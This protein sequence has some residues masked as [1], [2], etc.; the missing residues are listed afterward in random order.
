MINILSRQ[1]ALVAEIQALGPFE[2]GE[3]IRFL[4]G[5][6]PAAREDA[7]E[8]AGVLRMA[9]PVEGSWEYAG[10]TVRGKGT[11]GVEI[12]IHATAQAAPAALVQVRRILSLDVDGSGFA[13]LGETDPVVRRLRSRYPGLRPVLFHSPY[14]AACWAIIGNRIRIAQAARVKQQIAERAGEV[15]EVDRRRLIAFPAPEDLLATD[16][17]PDLLPAKVAQLNSIAEAARDGRLDANLLRSV[18]VEEALARLQKLPGIGPFSAQLILIRGAGHPDFFP[19]DEPRLHAEM[20][21]AYDVEGADVDELERIS[22]GWRPY[23]SWVG[24]LLRSDRERR[25]G[26]IRKVGA[27]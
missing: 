5:F 11:R 22:E 13:R 3:S 9:F 20:R 21:H 16:P 1:P 8:E 26:E 25:I 18:P 15:V 6:A 2:L 23:R 14:E 4:T 19:R 24:L 12:E 17:H 27:H 10:A 7:E